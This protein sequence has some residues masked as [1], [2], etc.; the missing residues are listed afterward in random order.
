MHNSTGR[1]IGSEES[2]DSYS[3]LGGKLYSDRVYD[4]EI[5][6]WLGAGDSFSAGFMYGY[7]TGDVQ[8]GL[9]Y[10]NAYAAVPHSIPGDINWSTLEEVE[11]QVKGAGLRISR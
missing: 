7:I 3:L 11:N 6:D 1:Y 10:G 2:L 5:V 8:K 9:K 4:V